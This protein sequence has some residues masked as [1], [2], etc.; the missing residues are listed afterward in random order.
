MQQPIQSLNSVTRHAVE[1]WNT[2]VTKEYVAE[3]V[4]STYHKMQLPDEPDASN[5]L[6]LKVP[7]AASSHDNMQRFWRYI[8][9]DTMPAK[10]NILDLLP[11]IIAV[12]PDERATQMLNTFLNPLGFSVAKIGQGDSTLSYKLLVAS[13]H[14]EGSEALQAM[15]TFLPQD[16]SSEQSILKCLK[17]LRESIEAHLVGVKYLE[18][19][20]ANLHAA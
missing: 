7:S 12:L 17:E 11:A 4:A 10:A 9:K 3:K 19:L 14:K 2:Q 6:L 5:E 18:S 13:L 16:S 15:L 20:L 8:T 1:S